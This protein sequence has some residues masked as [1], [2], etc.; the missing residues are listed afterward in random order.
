MAARRLSCRLPWRV[1][2]QGMDIARF[3]DI[4]KAG[5]YAMQGRGAAFVEHINGSASGIIGLP[6]YE[7]INLLGGEGFPVR[8]GWLNVG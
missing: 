4:G 7:T 1:L 5:A 6:L 8:L 3:D 2:Y